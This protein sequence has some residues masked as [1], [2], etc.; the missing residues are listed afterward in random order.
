MQTRAFHTLFICL[1]LL[2]FPLVSVMAQSSD[3]PDTTKV[4]PFPDDPGTLVYVPPVVIIM[5]DTITPD[6]DDTTAVVPEI[7]DVSPEGDS[8]MTYNTVENVLTISSANYEDTLSNSPVIS[9][10]GSDPLVIE[11]CDTSSITADT[12]ISSISD[13]VITG[14]GLLDIVGA[15]PIIGVPEANITFESVNMHV[16]SVG[17]AAAVRRYVRKIIKLDETGGPALSGFGS[18]DFNKVDVSPSDAMYGPI[19]GS[20]GGDDMMNCLYV[21]TEDG[22]EAVTEFNLT[23]K[24]DDYDAVEN[25]K[26]WRELDIHAPMYNILGLRVDATYRGI[27]IQAGQ[28]Y[29]H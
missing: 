10:F 23:A 22:P 19:P 14:D 12:I 13:I 4:P 26:V 29:L 17:T 6:P 20:D 11:V 3:E 1:L 7:I 15:V 8:T 16:S 9:Y 18:T 21:N 28:T 27:V 24:D 25:V 2:A 5:G